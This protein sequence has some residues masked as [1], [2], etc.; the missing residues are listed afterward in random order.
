[1]GIVVFVVFFLFLCVGFVVY[2]PYS[3]VQRSRQRKDEEYAKRTRQLFSNSYYTT[4]S[5]IGARGPNMSTCTFEDSGHNCYLIFCVNTKKKLAYFSTSSGPVKTVPTSKIIGS[6][7]RQNGKT[8]KE[9]GFENALTGTLIAGHTGAVVGA[10]LSAEKTR[11]TRYD[12]VIRFSDLND[13]SFVYHI[14]R[15]DTDEDSPI[16]QRAQRFAERASDLVYAIVEENR[17]RASQTQPVSAPAAPQISIPAGA[18]TVKKVICPNC[19]SVQPVEN[20]FCSNCGQ[21]LALFAAPPQTAPPELAAPPVPSAPD[22]VTL[23]DVDV[24]TGIGFCPKCRK[25]Q[26]LSRTYCWN[27]GQTF[28]E[29]P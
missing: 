24:Q 25:K 16:F 18:A 20:K 28:A 1:M 14:I 15:Q 7:I 17:S 19:E 6:E 21:K 9:N 2:I 5:E 12:L 27:C 22:V 4:L 10:V 8:V 13:S 29:L 26:R 11:V 23:V 3:F